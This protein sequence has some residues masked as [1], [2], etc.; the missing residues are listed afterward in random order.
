[1]K[2]SNIPIYQVLNDKFNME[3]LK[4]II[5][6]L[7]KKKA[8]D[9]DSITNE[10]LK[11]VSDDIMKFILAFLNLNIEKG[12]TCSQWCF[13]RISLI[14]KEGPKDDPNNYRGFA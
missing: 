4:S 11:L 10:F 6:E 1:M 13:D 12:M 8:V 7:K 5:K 9:P 3:E 14:H 2:K